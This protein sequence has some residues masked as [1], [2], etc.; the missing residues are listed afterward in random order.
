MYLVP[1]LRENVQIQMLG[2]DAEVKLSWR[3]GQIGAV[4]VFEN[5]EDAEKYADGRCEVIEVKES[6]DGK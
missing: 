5:K 2:L 6:G 1:I 4:P 3:N